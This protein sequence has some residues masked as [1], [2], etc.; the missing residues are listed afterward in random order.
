VASR[1]KGVVPNTGHST[2]RFT[3]PPI[4]I[5]P[6]YGQSI[7]QVWHSTELRKRRFF[8]NR[9]IQSKVLIKHETLASIMEVV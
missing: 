9:L 2:T 7:W 4:T 1:E 8:A 3:F 6:S 5:C